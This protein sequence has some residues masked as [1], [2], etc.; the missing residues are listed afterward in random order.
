MLNVATC[1]DLACGYVSS[2]THIIERTNLVR[3][4]AEQ[5]VAD[6]VTTHPLPSSFVDIGREAHLG[7]S[8]PNTARASKVRRRLIHLHAYGAPV[9]SPMI[10]VAIQLVGCS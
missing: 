1:V 7:G 6:I 4:G 10:S 5:V 3:V 8:L 9:S 2:S